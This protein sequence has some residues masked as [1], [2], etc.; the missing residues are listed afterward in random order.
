MLYPLHISRQ[1]SLELVEPSHGTDNQSTAVY[2]GRKLSVT[3]NE[4]MD[5]QCARV[6]Y[7]EPVKPTKSGKGKNAKRLAGS[8]KTMK[9][10][11]SF[12]ENKIAK[13]SPR[14]F[15]KLLNASLEASLVRST[16]RAHLDEEVESLIARFQEP[17]RE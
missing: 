12:T 3:S 15:M 5:T 7:R 13:K 9:S 16:Q 10:F 2:L 1:N 4:E 11:R 14:E 6:S 17:V 8:N